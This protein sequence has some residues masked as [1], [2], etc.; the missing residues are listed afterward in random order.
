MS[1]TGK[2]SSLAAASSWKSKCIGCTSDKSI[3]PK[4][5]VSSTIGSA[6][7][8]G[9]GT[10]A[11]S[12]FASSSI[13]GSTIGSISGKIESS[14]SSTTSGTTGVTGATGSGWAIGSFLIKVIFDNEV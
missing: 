12:G 1:S 5:F 9:G 11:T 6:C 10:I 13:I 14:G 3:T 4:P 7:S 8:I 2:L